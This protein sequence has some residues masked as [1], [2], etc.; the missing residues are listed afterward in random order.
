[1]KTLAAKINKI[2]VFGYSMKIVIPTN[3]YNK[4]LELKMIEFQHFISD[5]KLQINQM[6]II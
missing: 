3:C 4:L 1:M 5:W 6:F 2:S